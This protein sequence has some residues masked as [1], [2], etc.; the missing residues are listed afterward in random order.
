[1]TNPLDEIDQRILYH[2]AQDARHTSAPDITRD[3]DVSA[4]TIRN[5]IAQLEDRGVIQ[6]YHANIDYEKTGGKLTYLFI[7]DTDTPRRESIAK[8][9]LNIPGVIHV[10]EVMAGRNNLHIEA[11]GEDKNEITRIARDLSNL[12]LEIED[13]GLVQREYHHPYQPFGPDSVLSPSLENLM[14]LRELAGTAKVIDVTVAE[15]AP[16]VGGTIRHL[17]ETN[18]LDD[19][20][21]IVAIERE[22]DVIMPNGGTEIKPGDVVTV[23]SQQGETTTLTTLFSEQEQGTHERTHQETDS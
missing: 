16:A 18:R 17:S 1:M 8:E 15:S 19:G 10:R 13:E 21:L 3:L 4:A 14:N 5:R 22:D 12:G 6:G 23:L 7:C 11:I 20:L 9:S 2:L